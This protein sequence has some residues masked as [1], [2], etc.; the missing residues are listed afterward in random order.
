MP[1]SCNGQKR[2]SVNSSELRDVDVVVIG[3]GISG[4]A[5]A[6]QL[7]RA[8][9]SVTVLEAR[10]R[11]GG[12]LLG[13]P[14]DLGASWF[15]PGEQR[16]QA[17]AQRLEVETFEQYRAGDALIDELASV[18]RLPGNPIDVPSYRVVGGISS[19][20]T[21][22]AAELPPDTIHL[23]QPVQEITADLRIATPGQLWKARHAVIALPPA[24]AVQAIAL[25]RELPTELIDVAA[26]TPVWMGDSVKV[27]VHCEEPFWRK[28]GL[29]GAA[30]SRRGPLGELHDMSGP[31]GVPAAL[32]GF[33]RAASMHINIET[34]IREQLIRM[35][36]SQAVEPVEI[37]I[38]DWS[39]EQCTT[40]PS[41]GGLPDYAMFGHKVYQQPE[42]QGRLHWSSTETARTCAGHVEGALEAAERTVGS[43]LGNRTQKWTSLRSGLN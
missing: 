30:I 37:L 10:D 16:V 18:Q 11:V 26:R 40:P 29:A 41:T 31:D 9:L 35:F 8:G 23:Q 21:A 33:A 25:P 39:L 14:F 13:S 4:L 38:Q 17:L 5:V 20:A 15:W 27:V 7:I 43:I 12:R 19:L 2:N 36:G 42:L 6:D 32:F 1:H 22:L 34:D 28:D 3:A 24:L